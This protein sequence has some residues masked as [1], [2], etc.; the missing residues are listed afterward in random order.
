VLAQG[1]P[2]IVFILIDNLGY[3]E[4]GV[5]GGCAA[6]GAAN[7]PGEKFCGGCGARLPTGALVSGAPTPMPAPDAAIPA[8]ERRQ[9]TVLFCDLVGSTPLSQQ[10]DAEEWR[11]LLAQYQQAAAGAVGRFGGHVARKLGDGLLIYFGWPTAREDDPERAVRAGLA[12][13]DAMGPLNATLA[14]GDGPRLAVRIGLHTGP[15]VIAD[16]GEVFGE[17]ANLAARVQGTAAPDTVVITAATQRLV[18]GMFMVEDLGP[19]MLKGVRE[20]VTLYRIV[21]PSGVRSRLAVAAGRLTRFVGREIE[22]ATLVDRWERAQDGE[23]QTALVLGEAGIGKSRLVYQFHEHLTAV[24]HTWLECGGTP[25][26]ESTPFHPVIALVAQGLALG[27]EDTAPDQLGKLESGLG[28]LTSPEA[29]AL[30]AAFLG[31][32]P[33]TPLQMSPELQ[34]RRTIDLL[35]QWTLSLT[36]VQPLVVF[37]EDLHWCDASTL[38]LLGQVIAQSPTA[39]VLLLATARPEF[40]PPWPAHSKLTTVQLPRLTTHQARDMVTALGGQELAADTLDALVARADGVPLYIEELTKAIVAPG[41]G[42]GV[43]AI[44]ATLADSLMAR[45][46]RLSAAKEVAQRAAVLG[47]EFGYPLLAATAGLDEAALRHGMAHLIDAEILFA[48]GEPPAALY[49]FKHALIQETAYQSL[50]KRTRQQ[51]HARVAQVLQERFPERVAAEPEVVARHADAARLTGTAVTYYQ[52]AGEQAQERSAHEEAITQFRKAIALL[53]TLPAGPER[54]TREVGVQM[55]LSKSLVAA[56]GYAHAETE[57][58]WERARVLGEA[59]GDSAAVAE[60]LCELAG[61]YANRGEPD[62]SVALAQRVLAVGEETRNRSLILLGT[63]PTALANHY[64]GC[65]ASS[66]AH[67]E[68]VLALYDPAYDRGLTGNWR[69]GALGG[70][71]WNLWYLGHADR[72][73]GYAREGVSLA[74]AL[75]HP[76]ELAYALF[77]ETVVHRWR[78]DLGAQLDRA[79]EVIALGDAQDFPLWRGVGH[80]YHGLARVMAGEDTE[81]LAE[82]Q[83]GLALAAGAGNRGGAPGLLNSLAEGQRAAAQHAEALATVEN[84]LAVAAATGQHFRDASLHQLKGEL[85]LATA[86]A[87]SAEA[88]ALF[89]RALDIARAQEAKSLELRAAT[90]LARLWQR[91]GKPAEARALLSPVYAWFTEGFD[92][93]D[94]VEAK[95]LLDELT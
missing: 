75:G 8:G 77:F 80:V 60:A 24:P 72:A 16:D 70:A 53:G 63:I 73:L 49:T 71:A 82:V 51:L 56:R 85:L 86:P 45:L 89:R 52:R 30:L 94:L 43:A 36:A 29:V 40:T 6:C 2:N 26:T 41:A 90:S 84:G 44:P 78:G 58:A 91:Q 65:F 69:V 33:P 19:Q 12:I 55:A 39:R 35:V 1:Q 76:F 27:P 87:S 46:D 32:P 4:V 54:D 3:G 14:A 15:V 95:A 64:Q 74:R 50:L 34:R 25:Y 28:A 23:G 67:W 20:P 47:R 10:L 31:L 42:R 48:R 68:R 62:R 22:L 61:L 7:E 17:T 66:L 38:E 79:A 18:V 57:A 5:Y 88:D 93:G 13:V 37:V 9:L 81:G 11:D 92:T 21:Q 59:L 83:H